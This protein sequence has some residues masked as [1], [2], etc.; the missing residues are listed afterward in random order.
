MNKDIPTIV[1]SLEK[2]GCGIRN[3]KAGY[4]IL[5]PDG[6][7]SYTVH[8]SNHSDYRT[9]ANIRAAMKRHGLEV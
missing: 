7:S 8:K 6:K 5:F 1:R 4:M 3:T 2:Q 9:L